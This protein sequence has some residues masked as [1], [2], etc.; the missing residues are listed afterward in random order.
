MK[1]YINNKPQ[2]LKESA[3]LSETLNALNIPS[4]K[5]IAIAINNNVVAKQEWDNYCLNE[6]DQVT[7]IKATQGG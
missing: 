3:T 6:Q 5:G 4:Q 7:I 2:E 1:I